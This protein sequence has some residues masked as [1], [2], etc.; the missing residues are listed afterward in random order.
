MVLA[1]RNLFNNMAAVESR[2]LGLN[3]SFEDISEALES[4]FYSPVQPEKSL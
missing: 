1:S 2:T 3:H 4:V